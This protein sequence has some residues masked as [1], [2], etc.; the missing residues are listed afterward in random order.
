MKARIVIHIC[1]YKPKNMYIMKKIS[2][3]IIFT[4]LMVSFVKA[5]ELRLWYAQ[6]AKQWVEALPLGNSRL[7]VMVYGN[8]ANEELQ[9][10]EETVW[11]GGPHNNNGKGALEAL[12]DVRKLVFEG[13]NMEAQRLIDKEFKTPKNGMPYQTIGSLML[14]FEGHDTYTDYYRGLNIENAIATTSYKV[15]E[16]TYTREVFTS[17]TDNI[18]IIRLT[19][20]KEGAL[21]FA[22][23]YKSPL[24]QHSVK[25]KDGKLILSGNGQEHEGV[26]G[27]I[28]L[29]VQANIKAESGK[30]NVESDK[31]VVTDATTATIYVSVA[32]NFVNY[33]DVSGNESKRATA[34][35]NTALK[36]N[37]EKAKSEHIAYYQKQFN[38][39]KLDLGTSEAAKEQTHIRVKQ[40]NK[41]N[42]VSLAVLLFQYG[43][44]LLISSSQPGGQAANL[45]G[46]WNNDLLAPWDGKYT[47][48]INTEMNYWPAEV[49]N[50]S[51]THQPLFNMI[52]ELSEMGSKTAREMYGSNGWVAHH[53]TDIWRSC[54][55]VDGAYWG[56]WPNGGAWLSQ[57]LWEHYLYTGDE[58][59]LKD[60]YPV[61]K[62]SADFFLDFLVEHPV[63]KWMVTCPSNSPEHGPGQ[64]SII[65]GC[66]M[67]NQIAFDILSVTRKACRILGEDEEYAK[68]LKEMINRLPPMQIGQHNQL[69]EWLEDVDDPKNEHRHV[70]HLYGLYPSNQISPYSHPGLFQAAKN[71][72]IYRGDM[73]TGW[74]I[75][76]K[77][78]LWA[79]L[80][81][82]NHA[83]K[84]IN[85]MLVL[86]EPENEDGR[87]YTNLF[88][89]HPPF[90]IDGNFGYTAGVAE[91]LLQSHD[92][93]VHLLPAIPDV[94]SKGSVNGLKA[95]GGFEVEMRWSGIQLEEAVI[96]SSL[97][98]NLRLRSYVPLTGEGLKEALGD[99]P[100]PFF[101]K[102]DIK[103]PLMS[104]KI[105]NS[106]FPVLYKI[107]EYDIQT[108]AGKTYNFR[109]G[110]NL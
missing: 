83:F 3:Y 97:G 70:S 9:L 106:Q 96:T 102:P 74:S 91:M 110:K 92:G 76:W 71:S 93:A 65:A 10:N 50:L 87:T 99:N 30:V 35:M 25:K 43:R 105:I 7:G 8:P 4:F 18:I 67:D 15:G 82:G 21:S 57:H 108:E 53:N 26:P 103:E 90:Q 63:Y 78:N 64:S 33:E 72:L 68:R 109:R 59:F 11:G 61:L 13:K 51:E 95:R 46:I 52:K 27:A 44:Y 16:I 60:V 28:R 34:Y 98:G 84:I 23:N 104:E 6:P 37:Y 101:E 36:N 54:G 39:V 20:D 31:I 17:F 56:M 80:L 24:K 38:R 89:A 79:R 19:S 58:N 41:G 47:I 42:D 5:E 85:N 29:E 55:V 77:I 48:N 12:D 94:W 1:T 40:F 45:Q 107:Y 32:T 88:S 81:D 49:T 73:A 14:N 66:T 86:V 100:N 62:G 75:G 22:A 2:S 69:Q